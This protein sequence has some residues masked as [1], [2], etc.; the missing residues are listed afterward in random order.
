M[1]SLEHGE[2]VALVGWARCQ[3]FNGTP[4][5]D[6]LHAIPNGGQRNPAVAAKLKAEGVTPG[7]PDLMLTIPVAPYHGMFI[8]MKSRGG[9]LTDAQREHIER[10]RARGYHAVCCVGFDEA[11]VAIERYLGLAGR[12]YLNG[13]A[14]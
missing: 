1:R 4:I 7:I 8:E 5:S 10:L 2:Q 12:V 14:H 6:D 11:R 9:R 13:S 3:R